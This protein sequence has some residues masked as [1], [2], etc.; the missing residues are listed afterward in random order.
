M[1]HRLKL[2][3][4]H[5]QHALCIADDMVVSLHILVDLGTVDVDLHNLRLACEA[6]GI[7][8]HTVGE[9][10]AHGDEQVAAVAGHV[11]SLRTVHAD[12][13]RSE[14]IAPFEAA[15]A[16]HGYGN[17]CVNAFRKGE[18]FMIRPA[19]HHA[20]AADQKGLL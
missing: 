9:A 18:K 7:E 19:A 10:A 15:A 1:I 4:Q 5:L 13:A 14:R 6:C 20:A 2:V 16:H 12:H 3:Q 8:R 17:G 11:G